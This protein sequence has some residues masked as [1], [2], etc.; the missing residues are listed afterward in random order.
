VE[1][2]RT[3]G[4]DTPSFSM[5]PLYLRKGVSFVQKMGSTTT[6]GFQTRDT[7]IRPFSECCVIR[8]KAR[9][10]EVADKRIVGED[11]VARLVNRR[12]RRPVQV[13]TNRKK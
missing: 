12:S 5:P 9:S 4:I 11:D 13:Y 8:P 10:G 3:L 7:Y 1:L 2:L 6:C